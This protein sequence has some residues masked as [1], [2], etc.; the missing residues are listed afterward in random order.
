MFQ[1]NG[2]NF[3]CR[4]RTKSRGGVGIY[5]TSNIRYSVRTD[6]GLNIE[7]E[8]ESIF[9]E[10][11]SINH[12]FIV[13][14]IYR[15]PGTNTSISIARYDQILEQLESEKCDVYL[16]TDQNFDYAKINTSKPTTELF[17][18]FYSKGYLPTITKPTRI[19][20]ST[21]T[22]IDNIYVK[23]KKKLDVLSKKPHNIISGVI[24]SHIS[25]HLPVFVFTR[26]EKNS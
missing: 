12:R 21:A 19:T 8:F 24:N 22:I 11:K 2:Y 10:A 15:V 25:D 23:C 17:D 13:G 20:K 26:K 1:I 9:I 7:G 6:L 4:N 5:I 3:V 14:E 16:G 18:T